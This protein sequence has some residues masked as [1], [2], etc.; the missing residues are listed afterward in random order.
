MH[1][2]KIIIT[3][4]VLLC[5]SFLPINFLSTQA[6]QAALIPSATVFQKLQFPA[7]PKKPVLDEYHGIKVVDDYRWLEDANDGAV[8]QWIEA[9]NRFSRSLLENF[10][11]RTAIADRLQSLYN[12]RSVIYYNFYQRGMF[13]AM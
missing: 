2:S 5:L 9:Q 11:L 3:A 4:I 13:F 10:P 7:T 8:R 1:Q 6:R 12:R